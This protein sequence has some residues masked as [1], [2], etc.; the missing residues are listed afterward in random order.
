MEA[1]GSS[2][3]FL[4]YNTYAT[5]ATP[6]PLFPGFSSYQNVNKEIIFFISRT[7][8]TL[9]NITFARVYFFSKPLF[10]VY[11]MFIL[12]STP[13]LNNRVALLCLRQCDVI[14]SKSVPLRKRLNEVLRQHLSL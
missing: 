1:K 12:I 5:L 9:V 6:N 3:Q 7:I 8:K 4:A 2:G 11:L 14:N 10:D 13:L